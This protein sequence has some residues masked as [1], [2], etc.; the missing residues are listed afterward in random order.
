[1]GLIT[2]QGLVVIVGCAHIGIVNILKTIA[3]R[4]NIP[5]YAVIGGTHLIEADEVRIK[6]TID[7]L[8][9]MKLQFVAVS[10][11]TGEQ[12]IRLIS[13]ELSEQ[14]IYNNTG[15]VIVIKYKI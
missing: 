7:A 10:H 14:F 9:E 2:K 3:D 11:C 5:I 1:M 6:R 4:V 12:G 13:Q 8:K 15:N